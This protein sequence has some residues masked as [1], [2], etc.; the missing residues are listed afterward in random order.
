MDGN[1]MYTLRAGAWQAQVLPHL[2][3]NMISLCCQD[4]PILRKADEQTLLQSPF[5]YGTPLLFPAN[6]TRDG[7]FTF[8]GKTYDLPVNEESTRC[9]LHGCMH[10]APF[11]VTEKTESTLLGRYE[12]HGERYPF[13]FCMDI[14]D[15]LSPDGWT[16]TLTLCNTGKSSMP[17]TLAFHTAFVEPAR[18]C[19]PLAKKWARDQR[20]LPT[21]EEEPM[22]DTEKS[23][24]TGCSPRGKAISGY[25]Q[26]GGAW[27]RVGDFCFTVSPNFDQRVL[28]NGGGGQ[29]FL[30]IEP[31]AGMVNGLNMPWGFRVLKMGETERYTLMIRKAECV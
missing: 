25:F 29:G 17:Y 31:Q 16:R 10:H 6:R 2:G 20:Y 26:A 30:C 5:L 8:E 22:T 9:H 4:T 18:F 11:Q 24:L 3:M 19:L 1:G 14:C 13:P 23:Y 12:N 28:F 7:Q 27:A 15:V 21:G